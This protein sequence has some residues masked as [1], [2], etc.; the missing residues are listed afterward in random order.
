MDPSTREL[1]GGVIVTRTVG[2]LGIS[3]DGPGKTGKNPDGSRYF[4]IYL[5]NEQL[6]ELR[7]VD[8]EQL[9]RELDALERPEGIS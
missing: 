7:E 6:A 9:D 5:T 4:I 2:R 8:V 3:I 1:Q